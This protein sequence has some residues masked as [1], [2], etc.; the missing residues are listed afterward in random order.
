M[1][2]HRRPST[3]RISRKTQTAHHGKPTALQKAQLIKTAI[4][5]A[6]NASAPLVAVALMSGRSRQQK[7]PILEFLIR[8]NH[9]R[10][11][12]LNND[13]SE[14]AQLSFI[15]SNEVVAHWKKDRSQS[16]DPTGAPRRFFL[17]P[18]CIEHSA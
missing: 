4:G 6:A 2:L 1:Q 13:L 15:I 14:E 8:L 3:P 18:D 16:I 11:F 7:Q 9:R 17:L 10:Q 5:H 12:G